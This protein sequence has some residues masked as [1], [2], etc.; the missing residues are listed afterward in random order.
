MNSDQTYRSGGSAMGSSRSGLNQDVRAAAG[1][2]ASKISEVAQ[3][4]GS[5]AKQAAASIASE[6]NE[7][8]KGFLNQQVEAGADVVGNVAEAARRAADHLDHELPQIAGFVRSAADKVDEFS[9]TL[10]HQS[11]EEIVSTAS[12]F[13]RRQPAL[14]F[15]LASLAG[16]FLLR[17]LKAECSVKRRLA[18]PPLGSNLFGTGLD[19]AAL[20]PRSGGIPQRSGAIPWRMICCEIPSW[21]RP[22]ATYWATCRSWCRRKSGWLALR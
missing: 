9:Q 1:E 11:V 17:V 15:G 20:W 21:F 8:A 4:A 10:R 22:L 13:T 7:R 2:A 12:D 16:F 5:Q 18:G 14:V 19:P 6:A 3:Q